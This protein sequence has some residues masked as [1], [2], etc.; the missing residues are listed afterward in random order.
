MERI[1][2]YYILSHLARNVKILI[3]YFQQ[4]FRSVFRDMDQTLTNAILVCNM[5]L[6]LFV[7]I[8]KRPCGVMLPLQEYI[9]AGM[10]MDE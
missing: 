10:P 3:G 2:R 9:A 4:N 6:L 1:I 7:I 5:S 8:M